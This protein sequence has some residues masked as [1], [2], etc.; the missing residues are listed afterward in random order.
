MTGFNKFILEN[1]FFFLVIIYLISTFMKKKVGV[2]ID[3]EKA[4]IISFNG[5]EHRANIQHSQPGERIGKSPK[6]PNET[7]TIISSPIESKLR[8]PGDTTA[9]Q[10]GN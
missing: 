1:V 7:C 2:W 9:L 6:I 8:L 5:V 10:H 4:V 3:T